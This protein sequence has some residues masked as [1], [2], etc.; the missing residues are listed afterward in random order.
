MQTLLIIEVDS[1]GPRFFLVCDPKVLERLSQNQAN[2]HEHL[3]PI[4]VTE[5]VRET[6]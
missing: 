4:A 2:I 5:E 3:M 6:V 1:V